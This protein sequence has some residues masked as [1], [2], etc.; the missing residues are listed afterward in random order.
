[1][2]FS[3]IRGHFCVVH[4]YFCVQL[5]TFTLEEIHASKPRAI[6]V[7]DCKVNMMQITRGIAVPLTA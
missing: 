6:Y 3:C 4:I 2:E 5:R 7:K 1:M